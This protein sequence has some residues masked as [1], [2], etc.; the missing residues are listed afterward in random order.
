MFD[1]QWTDK[2]ASGVLYNDNNFIV[3]SESYDYR[4]EGLMDMLFGFGILDTLGNFQYQTPPPALKIKD[5]EAK[6]HIQFMTGVA[7]KSIN[8]YLL[9]PSTGRV[10]TIYTANNNKIEPY[11][12]IDNGPNHPQF[13]DIWVR[14]EQHI[15]DNSYIINHYKP[16][17]ESKNHIFFSFLHKEDEYMVIINKK[18]GATSSARYNKYHSMGFGSKPGKLTSN[19]NPGFLNDID[20]GISEYP[21]G[22]SSKGNYWIY[23]KSIGELQEKVDKL[24]EV[25][26]RI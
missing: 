3:I 26:K 4:K 15:K 7:R 24:T 11:L 18:T 10:D 2:L 8:K 9:I 20:G 23:S 25:Q 1:T 14:G 6:Q 5:R 12:I 17:L 13:K 22:L 21:N 16:A 19:E